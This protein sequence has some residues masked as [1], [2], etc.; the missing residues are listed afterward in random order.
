M[1]SNTMHVGIELIH[2]IQNG[3]IDNARELLQQLLHTVMHAGVDVRHIPE[4]VYAIRMAIEKNDADMCEMLT[5]VLDNDHSFDADTVLA[6]AY[7]SHR[8]FRSV[9][10]VNGEGL[11][12]EDLND[13]HPLV[14]AATVGQSENAKFIIDWI[15]SNAGSES[16]IDDMDRLKRETLIAAA[17]ANSV[18][19]CKMLIVEPAHA[20]LVLKVFIRSGHSVSVIRLLGL[21]DMFDFAEHDFELLKL[22]AP[23]PILLHGVMRHPSLQ[24]Y[25]QDMP[26]VYSQF[27]MDDAI[28]SHDETLSTVSNSFNHNLSLH[29]AEYKMQTGCSTR[30]AVT[31]AYDSFLPIYKRTLNDPYVIDTN[32]SYMTRGDD[33]Y[34]DG[35]APR[36][37]ETHHME[38]DDVDGHLHKV[39]YPYVGPVGDNL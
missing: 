6:A 30:H 27:A 26:T 10:G 28:S 2:K 17:T 38:R 15:R 39:T 29:A 16:V 35:P 25:R 13:N 5:S 8:V 24:E 7:K 31:K 18:A 33:P 9:V 23:F 4:Y 34:E 14:A 32:E 1:T 19:I 22:V 21:R 3:E 36:R 20:R 11:D 37:I 12:N